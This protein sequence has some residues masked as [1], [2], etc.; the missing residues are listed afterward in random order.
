MY[1][2]RYDMQANKKIMLIQQEANADSA[3]NVV[4]RTYY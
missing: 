1:L 3:D 4:L 2:N